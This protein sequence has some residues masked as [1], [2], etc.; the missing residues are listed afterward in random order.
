MQIKLLFIKETR[1]LLFI[2]LLLCFCSKAKA[3]DPHFSQFFASP[4]TL[5]P[6]FAG[7][8][9][10][11]VRA[12][13]NF[14]NQWSSINNAYKT[15]TA[16]VDMPIL[17]NTIDSRDRLGIGV[18][19][20]SDRTAN[21]AA[22]FNYGSLTAAFH[23]GL[24]EFGYHQIGLGLQATYANMVINTSQLQFED[25]LTALGFTN[26][27]SENFAN[28]TLK[29]H[30]FDM[31]AGLL[32]TGSTTEKNNFYFGVS[33]YHLNS[34]RQNFTQGDYYIK[35]RYTF[36]GGTYFPIGDI[37]SLHLSALHSIQSGAHETVAGG[38]LQ[39]ALNDEF[40]AV[41]PTNFYAGGWLRFGDAI[42][43]YIGM[44]Y[45]G[46]R[47]GVSYDVTT[48]QAKTISNS[49]G[50]VELS[51]IYIFRNNNKGYLPCPKF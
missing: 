49:R 25:Q 40:N 23:K 18:M 46:F 27:T 12:G 6:A 7:K 34:P 33:A 37:T 24:D 41:N 35:P 4:L 45:A 42:I 21:G 16:A 2:S 31:S 36:H 17:T 28:S 29:N 50:G 3:Q 44:D 43:P 47:L 26:V 30:Y 32:Y 13:V 51:L 39:F 19:G 10:G 8:F 14:R 22:N 11:D 15:V 48:S 1:C 38:T 5:N 20:Y 9:D